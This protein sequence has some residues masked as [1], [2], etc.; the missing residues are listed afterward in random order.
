MLWAAL[1]QPKLRLIAH[2][3]VCLLPAQLKI[4]HDQTMGVIVLHH[5]PQ[6]LVDDNH[7]A[8]FPD[9]A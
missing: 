2:L 5:I 3:L 8:G 9:L 6:P 7:V 4:D 1:D